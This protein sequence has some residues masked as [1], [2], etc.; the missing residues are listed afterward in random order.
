MVAW[1]LS[2]ILVASFIWRNIWTSNGEAEAG[3]DD[4]CRSAYTH[5]VLWVYYEHKVSRLYG[6]CRVQRTQRLI[7]SAVIG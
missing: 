2:F 6:A 3:D 7:S 1:C 4:S 5:W